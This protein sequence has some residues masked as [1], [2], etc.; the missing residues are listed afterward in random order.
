MNHQASIYGNLAYMAPEVIRGA[1]YSTAADVYKFGMLMYHVVTGHPPFKTRN[2]DQYLAFDICDGVRPQI[3]KNI[4]KQY[5]E[6]MQ[7]CW[8]ADI[9]NRPNAGQLLNYF[10]NENKK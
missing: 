3:T 6:L 9:A 5:R 8:D 2:H 1:Q 7:R 10:Y 4:P